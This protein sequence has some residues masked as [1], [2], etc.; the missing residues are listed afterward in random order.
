[1][2]TADWETLSYVAA[3]RHRRSV[4]TYLDE[5]GPSTPSTLANHTTQAQRHMSRTLT[6][7]RDRGLVELLV[8]EDTHKGQFYGL[9]QDGHE[10]ADQLAEV[11]P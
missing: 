7:L 5:N 1:M 9:T 2:T 8:P 10:I 4:I 11:T 3:G 6:Q